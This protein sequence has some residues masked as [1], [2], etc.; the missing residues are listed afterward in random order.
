MSNLLASDKSIPSEAAQNGH[1]PWDQRAVWIEELAHAEGAQLEKLWESIGL[2]PSYRRLRGPEIGLVMLRGR[3]GGVGDAFNLG[4]AT[5]TR[6]TVLLDSGEEGHACALGR[7]KPK[8]EIAAVCDALM[9]T[10]HRTR[11]IADL[12]APL[13]ARRAARTAETAEKAA[14]TRVEFFTMTRGDA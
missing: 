6:C 13:R 7:D 5:A 4:E 14:A 9:Q 10:E 11:L 8:A 1:D 3:V 2:K 12:L